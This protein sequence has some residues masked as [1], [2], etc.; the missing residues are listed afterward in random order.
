MNDYILRNLGYTDH[1]IGGD[2]VYTEAFCNLTAK[3]EKCLE[4]FFEAYGFQR[5]LP[6][7]EPLLSLYQYQKPETPLDRLSVEYGMLISI[8]Y[9]FCLIIPIIAGRA[10]FAHSR[11]INVGTADCFTLMSKSLSIKYEHLSLK[12]NFPTLKVERAQ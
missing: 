1:P 8:G 6:L 11:R 9:K 5:M 3:R 10:D 4:L 2:L 7:C 12:M